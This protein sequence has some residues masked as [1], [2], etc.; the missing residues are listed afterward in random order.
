MA[1]L[2]N[3]ASPA[4][5]ASTSAAEGM[6]IGRRAVTSMSLAA[7]P[8]PLAPGEEPSQA[9]QFTTAQS[10]LA[11][12][13]HDWMNGLLRRSRPMVL[14]GPCPQMKAHSSPSTISLV[15]MASIS[16]S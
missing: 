15:L 7:A 8:I 13:H 10:R 5:S 11:S 12:P 4:A 2:R 9:G 3:A 1:A 16:A 14:P 6:H